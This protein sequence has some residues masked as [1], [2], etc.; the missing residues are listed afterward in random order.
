MKK[1]KDQYNTLVNERQNK[2]RI[3]K[4]NKYY[5]NRYSALSS[6]L[7]RLTLIILL[8]TGLIWLNNRGYLGESIP[9]ILFPVLLAVSLFY[10]LKLYVDVQSR[11]ATDYDKYDFYFNPNDPKSEGFSV[12]RD[13]SGEFNRIKKFN[14]DY[15]NK[16]GKYSKIAPYVTPPSK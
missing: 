6:I 10:I 2:R 1:K 11:N 15:D 7:F 5:E 3:V 16:N 14:K 8:F 13:I 4:N 9:S 12:L